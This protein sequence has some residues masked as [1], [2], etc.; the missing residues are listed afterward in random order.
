M[1]VNPSECTP[2]TSRRVGESV[3]AHEQYI[4]AMNFPQAQGLDMES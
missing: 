4:L 2:R 1:I 3:G